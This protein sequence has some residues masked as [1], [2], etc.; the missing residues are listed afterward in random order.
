MILM[1]NEALTASRSRTC[2]RRGPSL[3]LLMVYRALDLESSSMCKLR[4]RHG[5]RNALMISHLYPIDVELQLSTE[6][7]KSIV[8]ASS[9]DTDFA[10]QL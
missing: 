4:M 8:S 9:C 3:P 1:A 2:V 5:H 7:F 6:A 10:Q